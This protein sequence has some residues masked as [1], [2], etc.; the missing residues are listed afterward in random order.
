MDFRG[1]MSAEFIMIAG[2]MLLVSCSVAIFIGAE[3]EL[4]H[5]MAAARTGAS[6][7]LIADSLSIYPDE[8]FSS[9]TQEHTRLLS[10]SHVKIV[11]ISYEKKE[12]NSLYNRTHI[13]LHIYA[14]GSSMNSSDLNCLGDRIN[15]YARRSICHVFNTENL[16][17]SV[18][19]PAFTD[20]Y[21]VTTADVKWV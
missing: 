9:Y 3:S 2:F 19:N 4:T 8:T 10:T 1:Q 6:E 15:Y 21:V 13:Q 20:K 7:G 5:A 18:Y 12:F 16:T 11:N 14:T 17:N